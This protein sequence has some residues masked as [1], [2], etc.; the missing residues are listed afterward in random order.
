[1]ER[2]FIVKNKKLIELH[3]EYES[4]KKKVNDAFVE[5][6]EK[7]GIEAKEYYQQTG[8]LKIVPTENDKQ[9][10]ASQLTKDGVTFRKN[11][12]LAKEWVNT[13][14][15]LGLETPWKPTWELRRLVNTNA[16]FR[17]RLFIL[18]DVLYG[19]FEMDYDFELPE[20][21][22]TELKASEFWKIV[23]DSEV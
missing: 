18:N 7:H 3:K 11:S 14:K 1:M 6:S 15:E 16:R 8:H 4:M 12:A 22:F 5:F 2:F 13:C 23:E 20:E 9:K 19:S 21:H 17:S 10:F